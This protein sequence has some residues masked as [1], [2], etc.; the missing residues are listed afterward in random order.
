MNIVVTGDL[1]RFPEPGPYPQRTK[2]RLLIESLGGRL[3]DSVSSKTTVLVTN[4]PNS[5]TTKI[6]KA[7]E[8]GI[9]II[10]EEE[11]VRRYLTI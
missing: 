10:S 5:G 3:T 4:F 6:K 11:F 1:M 7:K 8:L 9:E 2:L